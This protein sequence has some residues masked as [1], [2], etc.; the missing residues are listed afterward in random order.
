VLYKQGKFEAARRIFD[1]TVTAEEELLHAVILDH[2][3]DT[4][5]RLGRTE[6]AV[7]LWKRALALARKD[8]SPDRETRGVLRGAAAKIKAAEAGKAP[9]VAPLGKGV[10]EPE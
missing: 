8:E 2:A 7:A 9:P 10:P 5:W 4:L 3:G 6:R 1:Q